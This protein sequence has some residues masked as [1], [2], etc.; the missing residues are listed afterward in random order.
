[1]ENQRAPA[2]FSTQTLMAAQIAKRN[3]LN[4]VLSGLGVDEM[5][6]GYPEHVEASPTEFPRVEDELLWRCQSFYAWV[7]KA[8]GAGAGVD[9]RFP[10]LDPELIALSRGL[11]LDLKVN[12]RDTK[13]L[14]RNVLRGVL[15]EEIVEAGRIAG[16]KGGFTPSIAGW[17]SRGLGDW[18]KEQLRSVPWDLKVACLGPARY[19][20]MRLGFP[21][22]H[23]ILLRLATVPIFQQQHEEGAY[24]EE[25]SRSKDRWAPGT[26]NTAA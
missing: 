13:I 25:P 9:V 6:G 21:V 15:P 2:D 16:T 12:G 4:T 11:P 24:E 20:K 14:L 18:V 1:V 3:G 10:F 7:Q 19:A 5:L 26:R 8:Q 17:W 22:N 23:W